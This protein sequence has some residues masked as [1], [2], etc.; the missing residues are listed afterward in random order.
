MRCVSRGGL[1]VRAIGLGI[2]V[3]LLGFHPALAQQG[4]ERGEVQDTLRAPIAELDER[5]GLT[6]RMVDLDGH[7]MRVATA[8][9]EARRP[10]ARHGPA[11]RPAGRGRC[12][13]PARGHRR[14]PLRDGAF[15][16]SAAAG[17][18][19]NAGTKNRTDGQVS[20]PL[21]EGLQHLPTIDIMQHYG[22]GPTEWEDVLTT[23]LDDPWWQ[24]LGYIADRDSFATPAP[25]V[26][27]WYDLGAAETLQLFNLMRR[28]AVD[29]RTREHQYVILSPTTHCDSERATE[30]TRVGELDVGY[31]R[32]P[33]WETYLRWFDHWL[34]GTDNGVTRMPRVQ[35]YV[36]GANEWRSADEWPVPAARPTRLYLRSG[37]A[38]G[39]RM[40]DGVLS[41]RP[42]TAN[43]PSDRSAHRFRAGHRVRV[44]VSSSNFPRFDRNLNTGGDNVTETEWRTAKNAV[45]HSADHPSH[46]LLTVV[47]QP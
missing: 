39:E 28:N 11:S 40:D 26:N 45:H 36:T 23:P 44:E 33:Y 3:T 1:S 35:Y 32:F 29:E 16:L 43:E 18:F 46:V 38:A 37:G 7:A 22:V 31:A 25:H 17:W 42:P 27:S 24:S 15:S 2:V 21:P 5:S 41:R 9:L 12:R 30:N 6:T 4:A 8:G 14:R 20:I 34:K 47:D 10:G 19:P 13:S